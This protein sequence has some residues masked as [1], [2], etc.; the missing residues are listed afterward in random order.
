MALLAMGAL[1]AASL[2]HVTHE[3]PHRPG[4]EVTCAVCTTPLG[5]TAASRTLAPPELRPEGTPAAPPMAP[6]AARA[7]LSFSPKQS[8]PASA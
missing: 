7:P 8:P 2:V 3:H 1:L 5:Q 6:P 4:Q